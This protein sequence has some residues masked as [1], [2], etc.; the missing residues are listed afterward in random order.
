[1]K[2]RLS[3]P[4]AA[5]DTYVTVML[6]LFALMKAPTVMR[7]VSDCEVVSGYDVPCTFVMTEVPSALGSTTE[8]S[9]FTGGSRI[10]V[11]SEMPWLMTFFTIV[12]ESP[13]GKSAKRELYTRVFS[14]A[15]GNVNSKPTAVPFS[16]GL[17]A[18]WLTWIVDG[19]KL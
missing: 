4:S 12:D 1:V 17:G 8:A 15:V 2:F 7:N 18:I 16:A 3:V 10:C 5:V 9:P 13:A 6:M 14:S 11:T 19:I